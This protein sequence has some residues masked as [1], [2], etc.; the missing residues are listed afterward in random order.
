MKKTLLLFSILCMVALSHAQYYSNLGTMNMGRIGLYGGISYGGGLLD[1]THTLITTDGYGYQ[2]YN[3][4]TPQPTTLSYS[5]SSAFMLTFAYYT[6][7]TDRLKLGGTGGFGYSGNSW[8]ADFNQ[9]SANRVLIET[10]G[11]L[12]EMQVGFSGEVSIVEK[13]ALDFS[14]GPYF[15]LLSGIRTRAEQ[16]STTGTLVTDAEA[17]EWHKAESASQMDMFNLDIGVYG[18]VGVNYYI[19]ETLWVGVAGQLHGPFFNPASTDSF[20][21]DSDKQLDYGYKYSEIKRKNWNILLHFGIDL[22]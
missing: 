10:K 8:Q 1:F 15:Q 13:V 2:W 18:R 11:S 5:P 20:S 21:H 19:T 22:D 17:N 16:Y 12:Y 4:T 14:V 6:E 9:P 3:E 7:V